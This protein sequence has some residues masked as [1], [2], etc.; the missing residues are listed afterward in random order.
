MKRIFALY[1][2]SSLILNASAQDEPKSKPSIAIL[3]VDTKG[4]KNKEYSLLYPE[5]AGNVLRIET[6]KLNIYEVLDR[7]DADYIIK[8]KKLVTEN[9]YGKLCLTEIGKELGVDKMLSGTMENINGVI[10][11]S[12]R[13]IDVKS[14]TIEKTHI[15]EFLDIPN[16]LQNIT[17]IMLRELLGLETD[18][19]LTKTLSAKNILENSVNTP[20]ASR[21]KL[22]GPR[23][24]FT[25]LT[26]E[27]SSIVQKP[28]EEGGFDAFPAMFQ[29][30]YQFEARYLNEGNIQAL[31]EFI[32]LITGLDQGL[33]IP[34]LSILHGLRNN[35]NGWEFAFGPTL[36]FVKKANGYYDTEGVWNLETNWTDTLNV[37]PHIIT[38]RI[39]SRGEMNFTSGFVI[40]AGKTFRS[41]KLNIPVNAY[42][43]PNRN[44]LRFGL[45]FGFNAKK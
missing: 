13:L 12:L 24:G 38:T 45:S 26:G 35:K 28:I 18:T 29:F 11:Y 27:Y 15:H 21:L 40:A 44:G 5:E 31:F 20:Y 8:Q 36:N 30:G 3:H 39:D 2:L 7:Y 17:A 33:F 42:I 34:S 6:E 14:N 19:E 22:D 1:I 32:P 16:Q 23:M 4:I 25:V 9:C 10:Y 37:N 41:G 43:I